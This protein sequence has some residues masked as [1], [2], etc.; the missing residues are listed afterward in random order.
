MRW[1]VA[2]TLALVVIAC[3]LYYGPLRD[4]LKQEDAYQK[5]LATLQ[6]L[7]RQNKTVKDQI[8]AVGSD[9]WIA[10][11]ARSQ[12]QLVPQ[13]TQAF[14]ITDLPSDESGPKEQ[15]PL[16]PTELTLGQRLSDL[17]QALLR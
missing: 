9:T 13:G 17:W 3:G 6:D 1:G 12:F 10:R 11:E 4:F 15:T 16:T 2:A 5:E 14:V 7:Q 8:A